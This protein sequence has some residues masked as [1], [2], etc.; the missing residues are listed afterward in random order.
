MSF[1]Y[2]SNNKTLWNLKEGRRCLIYFYS[3]VW[4]TTKSKTRYIKAKQYKEEWEQVKV[5]F[6]DRYLLL[7]IIKEKKREPLPSFSTTDFFTHKR[8]TLE[9]KWVTLRGKAE[10]KGRRKR[11][12]GGNKG[13]KKKKEP[14][15]EG[16]ELKDGKSIPLLFLLQ[17]FS[18]KYTKK[19]L[20]F[21]YWSKILSLPQ[22]GLRDKDRKKKRGKD[23]K[24]SR[25]RQKRGK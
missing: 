21:E 16:F 23:K 19:I 14:W 7:S 24:C 25:E 1:L 15:K 18:M 5:S 12:E 13:W 17:H 4:K 9:A 11:Q 8:R 2:S 22:P 20:E 3:W 10:Q 6:L